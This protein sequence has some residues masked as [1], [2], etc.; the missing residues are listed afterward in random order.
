M[1]RRSLAALAFAALALAPG[2]PAVAVESDAGGA[3]PAWPAADRALLKE[4]EDWLNGLVTVRAEFQQ[5]NP[6]GGLD[7]GLL[8]LWRPGRARI[9]YAPPT[10]VLVVADGT[11]LIYFDAE[12]DQVSHVPIGSGPFRLL[13]AEH[14]SLADTV[15]VVGLARGGGLVRMTVI[16]PENPDDGSVTLV[17]DESPLQ[18]R[19]WEVLDAQGYVTTVTLA[20]ARY[21]ESFDRKMFYF[22]PSARKRDFR[23]GEHR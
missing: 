11:W 1:M 7:S 8:W 21:G 22:P 5:N 13:L 10:D 3:S 14:V 19:Q 9:E 12:L 16:D 6:D 20:D 23:V 2:V 15:Q 17:F 18:L 4:I